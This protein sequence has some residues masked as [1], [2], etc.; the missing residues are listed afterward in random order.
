MA[1]QSVEV[2]LRQAQKEREA[3]GRLYESVETR[4]GIVLG[5][6]GVLAAL[7]RGASVLHIAGTALAAAA[8]LAALLVLLPRLKTDVDLGEL[9]DRYAA[10]ETAFATAALLDATVE[11]WQDLNGALLVKAGRLKLSMALLASSVATVTIGP[12]LR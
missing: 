12:V 11:A 8:A 5:F 4:A 1:G 7:S 9:R 10:A 3:R 2:L 6:A